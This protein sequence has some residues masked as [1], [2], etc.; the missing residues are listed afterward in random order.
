MMENS[1]DESFIG[2]IWDTLLPRFQDV[3]HGYG[4]TRADYI[5]LYTHVYDYCT[6]TK[7]VIAPNPNDKN[8]NRSSAQ[9]QGWE[10]Y[11]KIRELLVEYQ[12]ALLTQASHLQGPD[13][14]NFYTSKWEA[15]KLASRTLDSIC[16]YL[17]RH[18]VV[19]EHEEQRRD[20][21]D[22]YQLAMITWRD[23][24]F[25]ALKQKL[26]DNILSLIGN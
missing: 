6:N 3:F 11:E 4:M 18:W 20:S 14:L 24:L 13:L 17:D 21:Y 10:L 16:L 26:I 19:R 25:T 8:E 15:Y 7:R 23:H 12:K 1:N 22:I 9:I 5:T 2:E